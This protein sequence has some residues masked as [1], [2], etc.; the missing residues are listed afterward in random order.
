MRIGKLLL[1]GA[2]STVFAAVQVTPAFAQDVDTDPQTE[3]A[4]DS[5]VIIVT[6]RKREE[7][8]QSVPISIT[9]LTEDALL[10]ANAYGLEDVAELTPGLQFRQLGGFNEVTIRGLAQTDQNSL[11]SNVGVFID[12]IFLNNRASIEFGNLDLGRVEV[13][14]GPQSALFGR[15]TFAGAINYVTND[16]VFGEFEGSVEGQVGS[17]DR[18]GI[19]GSVNVPIGDFG[20]VRVF[21]GHSEFDGTIKNIRGTGADNV[22]GWDQRFS[23][24][25]KGLFEF[26]PITLTAFYARNEI[27][28][29]TTAFALVD[30]FGNTA[31]SNYVVPDGMGGTLSLWTVNT[32]PFPAQDAVDLDPLAFGNRG[33]FW[34][35][36]ANLDFDLDFATLTANL[37][38]SKSSYRAGFDSIGRESAKNEPFFGNFSRQFLTDLTG[39]AGEQ[40]S[41]EV[42]LASNPGSAVDWLVGY[43][44]YESLTGGVL[45]TTV[46]LVSDPETLSTITRVEEREIVDVDAVFASVNIPL[47]AARIFGE[48]RYTEEA[49]RLTDKA[50]IF[51]LPVLSRPLTFTETDFD[52]WSGKIG[53]DVEINP[54]VLLYAYAARGVKSGGINGGRDPS[55]EF[56]TFDPEFNWT[57]ELGA[58]TTLW[59][60]RAIVNVAAFYIDWSNLQAT[61]PATFA[62]GPVTVNG[63]GASSKGV[64]IDA[65]L[66]ITDNFNWRIAGSYQDATYDDGFVDGS[67]ELRC[68][69]NGA[70]VVPVSV[71]SAEVGGNQIA[72][73]SDLNF[74]TAAKY[75]IPEVIGGF[76]L[77]GRVSYSFEAGKSPTALNL[78][79]TGDIELVTL[80]IGLQDDRTEIAF[81]VDNLFDEKYIARATPIT[82][83]AANQFCANCGISS[84]QTIFGNGRSWGVTVS[85]EF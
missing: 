40:D 58:K 59:D 14:K 65:S 39:D 80:R 67:I 41:F 57:Y 23:L 29:D 42:R 36:Y 35:A 37:S 51:F 8:L 76:D 47:G 50:D 11:Q 71:C 54:D 79:D 4:D 68:G 17:D 72:N 46:R 52:F 34:L 22:G 77:Y 64:E 10:E 74:Y 1:A 31:G 62:A 44:R 60:G 84:T 6:A 70:T 5:R 21:G 56:G 83:A 30:F 45:S 75:T 3:E 15:N 7:D 81:W 38:K 63:T 66:D 24:G 19:K 48:V 33:V 85:R 43:S 53:A 16:P 13:L 26:G 73:S 20:A 25:A 69:V 9:A 78:A 18:Y 12:G 2:A 82:E 28:E 55:D 49:Y 27:E 32:G 61:A